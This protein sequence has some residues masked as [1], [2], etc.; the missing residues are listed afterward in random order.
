MHLAQQRVLA[1]GADERRHGHGVAALVCR[2]GGRA[3]GAGGRACR[4]AGVQVSRCGRGR[5]YV[6]YGVG[7]LCVEVGAGKRVG[8]RA[9]RVHCNGKGGGVS[10]GAACSSGESFGTRALW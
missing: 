1:D 4:G 6:W 2:K 8:H 5:G 7:V 3:G 10:V 9:V